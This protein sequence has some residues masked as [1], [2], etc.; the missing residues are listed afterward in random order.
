MINLSSGSHPPRI[1]S[2][3]VSTTGLSARKNSMSSLL[4]YK[5]FYRVKIFSFRTVM[6]G[7]IL[8]IENRS[9]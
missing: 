6:L 8:N 5:V 2:G 7:L 1:I 4:A 9:G 3:G